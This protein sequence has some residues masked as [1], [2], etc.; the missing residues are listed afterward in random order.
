[1]YDELVNLLRRCGKQKCKNCEYEHVLGCVTK[2]NEKA[3]D[4]IEHMQKTIL[5]LENELGIYDDLPMVDQSMVLSKEGNMSVLIKGM[6][7]PTSCQECPLKHRGFNGSETVH[8]CYAICKEV[9]DD[10]EID[11]AC[12]LIPIPPHGD[13]ID[14]DA[15]EQDAHKR[16]LMCNKNDNH[17]QKP[18]EVMR[19]IALAPTIIPAE[20]PKEET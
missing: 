13:L 4:A 6:K 16:L 1:M 9:S 8:Y 11:A 7:M 19:A 14:R 15:L 17:F 12:P 20:P 5:R 2:M 18:Y 10:G 3:A